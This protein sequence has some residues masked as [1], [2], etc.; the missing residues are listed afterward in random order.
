[1]DIDEMEKLIV[2]QDEKIELLEKVISKQDI[3][4]KLQEAQLG[5]A[6]A[7]NALQ[8]FIVNW[9]TFIHELSIRK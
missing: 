4:I 2:L 6:N 7:Q 9:E 8:K 3:I 5:I 1:M